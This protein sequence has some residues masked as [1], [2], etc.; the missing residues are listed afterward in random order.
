MADELGEVEARSWRALNARL[1]N[2]TRG[3]HEGFSVGGGEEDG[4]VLVLERE[5]DS[6][7]WNSLGGGGWRWAKEGDL[8]EKLCCLSRQKRC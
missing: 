2:F 3:S 4:Q 1:K 5:P 6:R 8:L 7:I